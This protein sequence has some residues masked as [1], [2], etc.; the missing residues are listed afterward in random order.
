[1]SIECNADSSS[2]L[3]IELSLKRSNIFTKQPLLWGSKILEKNNTYDM[4]VDD[5]KNKIVQLKAL[6]IKSNLISKKINITRMNKSR[7]RRHTKDNRLLLQQNY[8]DDGDDEVS[9]VTDY[10]RKNDVT[11]RVLQKQNE[12]NNNEINSNYYSDDDSDDNDDDDNNNSRNNTFKNDNNYNK[13]HYNDNDDEDD[14]VISVKNA[15]IKR[16]K[17]KITPSLVSTTTMSTATVTSLKPMTNR[18]ISAKKSKSSTNVKTVN[19]VMYTQYTSQFKNNPSMFKALMLQSPDSMI[20]TACQNINNRY[21]LE[22]LE[23]SE[24]VLIQLCALQKKVEVDILSQWPAVKLFVENNQWTIELTQNIK[25]FIGHGLTLINL[26]EINHNF[27]V[28]VHKMDGFDMF[29]HQPRIKYEYLLKYRITPD[30]IHRPYENSLPMKFK[31]LSIPNV[32]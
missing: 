2:D 6:G 7:K 10:C 19:D 21:N 23:W 5:Q 24:L 9:I 11:E 29:T 22:I 28:S 14:N 18:R 1:M 12:N 26:L 27:K 31:K 20:Q 30:I 4:I 13:Y 17:L 16:R 32:L 25:R 15:N 3:E 8:D